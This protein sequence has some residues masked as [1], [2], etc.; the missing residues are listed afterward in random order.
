MK[1]VVVTLLLQVLLALPGLR[2]S[3]IERL[4][5]LVISPL[6]SHEMKSYVVAST[7]YGLL[8]VESS[9]PR[10]TLRQSTGPV[11]GS[12]FS[13]PGVFIWELGTG[14]H[15]VTLVADGF[16]ALRFPI[17][18]AGR[19][20][21]QVQQF[22]ISEGIAPQTDADPP[23]ILLR[24]SLPEGVSGVTGAIDGRPLYLNCPA[25]HALLEPPL[26][27]HHVRLAGSWGGWESWITLSETSRRI[28]QTVE[29]SAPK[30]KAERPEALA[31]VKI[32][33]DPPGAEVIMNDAVVGISPVELSGVAPGHY[34]VSLILDRHIPMTFGFDVES[35]SGSLPDDSRLLDLPA[36]PLIPRFGN[37]RVTSVPEGAMVFLNGVEKGPTPIDGMELNPG[38]HRLRLELPDH[39]TLM[40]AITMVP[41]TTIALT[42]RLARH[43]GQV[44]IESV[45][46]DAE[47][48]VDGSYWS[49][50]PIEDS[51]ATGQHSVRL[52]KMRYSDKT[53]E[54]S[55]NLHQP[56]VTNILL[57]QYYGYLRVDSWPHRASVTLDGPS[58]ELIGR[59]LVTPTSKL[60]VLSGQYIIHYSLKD[61]IEKSDTIF[62]QASAFVDT[63]VDLT[64]KTGSLVITLEDGFGTQIYLKG[65]VSIEKTYPPENSP[66]Y[67]H[68][69]PTGTYTLTV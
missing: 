20:E 61:Y 14:R 7:S 62:V 47:V 36:Y 37:L 60:K 56:F 19:G 63:L 6:P 67:I 10:I 50:T 31:I 15:V 55:A 17:T 57:D 35:T 22:R 46:T 18:V 48:F 9:I 28:E 69:V 43:M 45:P 39:H 4:G 24:M 53:I 66:F 49:N 3:E 33:S 38:Q 64:R 68:E 1:R 13:T 51:L 44:K 41:D 32:A 21:L 42:C 5:T 58:P 26:G 54:L 16:E 8:V 11:L 2:A 25:G 34:Q 65:E 40:K 30:S 27:T 12:D 29:W 52:R 59:R 23:Q